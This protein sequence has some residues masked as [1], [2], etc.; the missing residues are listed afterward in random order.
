M[1]AAPA[2][3]VKVSHPR[4]VYNQRFVCSPMIW[5]LPDTS[6]TMKRKGAAATPFTTATNT[7]SL[8]GSIPAAL[9]AVPATVPAMTRP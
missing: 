4:A 2:M 8:I 7:R 3:T 5:R 1:I 9:K 6:I